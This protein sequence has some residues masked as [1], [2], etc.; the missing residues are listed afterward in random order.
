M[1]FGNKCLFFT[2]VF[3]VSILLGLAKAPMSMGDSYCGKI[4][5]VEPRQDGGIIFNLEGQN[6]GNFILDKRTDKNVR[7]YYLGILL[8]GIAS[9]D[10]T[11]CVTY[12]VDNTESCPFGTCGM[13]GP[14]G[15]SYISIQK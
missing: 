7:A 1:K 9:T 11:I 6:V 12:Y 2:S 14:D 10:T 4:K 5:F 8:L 3:F 13:V 15:D